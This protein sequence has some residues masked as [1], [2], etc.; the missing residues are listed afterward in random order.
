MRESN[1]LN[2]QQ[3]NKKGKKLRE[4]NRKKNAK[5]ERNSGGR[6]NQSAAVGAAFETAYMGT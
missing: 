4:T 5:K 3:S 2:F 6:A 1:S